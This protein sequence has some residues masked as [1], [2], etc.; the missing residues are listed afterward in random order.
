MIATG[1]WET[2]ET[3]NVVVEPFTIEPTVYVT[4]DG[5]TFVSDS[6]KEFNYMAKD[7]GST[8][9]KAAEGVGVVGEVVNQIRIITDDKTFAPDSYLVVVYSE[10]TYGLEYSLDEVIIATDISSSSYA[11][12][13]ITGPSID[14]NLP[15]L[16]GPYQDVYRMPISYDNEAGN[17]CYKP[18]DS[19][20]TP[21]TILIVVILPVTG[22]Y[23][24]ITI[25]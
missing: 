21:T 22:S 15:V 10:T 4:P 6:E 11:S 8:L 20:I 3:Y 24:E 17:A 2:S 14:Q 7:P 19:I 5:T 13:K 9:V 16:M 23:A 25:P 1:E 12:V 18:Y